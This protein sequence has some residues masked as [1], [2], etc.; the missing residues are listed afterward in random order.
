MS[1]YRVL[2][3]LGEGEVA[4]VYLAMNPLTAQRVALKCL[5][6]D[7]PVENTPHYLR[8][9]AVILA[10]LDHPN[11]PS[12]HEFVNGDTLV[13]DAITGD[14]GE[15]ILAGLGEGEFLDV[16]RVIRWGIQIA[17]ILTYLHHHNPAIAFCD[18]KPAHIMIDGDDRA[19]L[20]DFNLSNILPDT[21]IITDATPI[22]TVGFAPPEQYQ[23][24]VSP[25]VDIYALGATL[26]YLL[27]R[28]DPRKERKFTFAPIRSI[29]PQIPKALSPII[30]KATAFESDERYPCM[31]DMKA[32]LQGILETD[33]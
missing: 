9:E 7:S 21:N 27:T 25:L 11:I 8:N 15:A 24:I 1:H 4:R 29:N 28:I 26:H 18:L 13:M 5:R 33:A 17:D 10:Q 12:F 16:R 19:W 3:L 22:G 23:G 2:R 30:M 31:E 14:D 32:D 6:G 20:V